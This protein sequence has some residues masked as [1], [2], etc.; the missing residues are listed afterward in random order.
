[1]Q[2]I[3]MIVLAAVAGLPLGLLLRRNLANLGYR[4]G[5]EHD[6]PEP[7]PRWW[8]VW[9]SVL[10]LGSSA[11][12]A[13]LSGRALAYLP[14]LP[15]VIAGPWLAAVDFDVLRIPNRVL[16]PTAAATLLAVGGT[17]AVTQEWRTLI[18]PAAAA[19]VTGGVFA[20][21]HIATKGGIGFGDVKVA[22]LIGLAVGP[23]GIAAV[24]LAVLAGTLIALVW[25]AASR[26]VGPIPYGPWLLSGSWFAAV[27]SAFP[28]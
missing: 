10:A 20:A 15:L 4:I 2:P 13:S 1:M 25:A 17:V 11:S 19:V 9:I 5:D 23:L 24:W 27:I 18:V 8:V 14:L 3:L 28:R 7:G 16:A 26:R 22:A 6:L 12:A 21:I